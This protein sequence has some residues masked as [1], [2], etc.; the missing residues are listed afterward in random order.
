MVAAVGLVTSPGNADLP[1]T[2]S[3]L[4]QTGS[5]GFIQRLKGIG[6]AGFVYVVL[7]SHIGGGK[8]LRVDGGRHHGIVDGLSGSSVVIAL[9]SVEDHAYLVVFA[10]SIQSKLDLLTV[11]DLNGSLDGGRGVLLVARP[12][13]AD[14]LVTSRDSGP[15]GLTYH[16]LAFQRQPLRIDTGEAL[17]IVLDSHIIGLDDIRGS[18]HS[19]EDSGFQQIIIYFHIGTNS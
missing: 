17:I 5:I 3:E 11:I 18:H 14:L 16:R 12:V 2:G 4:H 7:H 9:F 13:D 1:G 15:T 8:T 19:I 6:N 10:V